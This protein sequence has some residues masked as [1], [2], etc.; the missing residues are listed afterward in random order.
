[1]S[2]RPL[3]QAARAAKSPPPLFATQNTTFAASIV[4]TGRLRY[5]GAQPVRNGNAGVEVTF[6]FDDPDGE[7]PLLL[8][9]FKDRRAALADPRT[10]FEAQ[11]FLKSEVKRIQRAAE[12][13]DARSAPVR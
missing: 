4:A 1:M 11:N 12:V 7:G 9:A 13:A 5:C 10:L 3:S 2:T 8:R 6:T